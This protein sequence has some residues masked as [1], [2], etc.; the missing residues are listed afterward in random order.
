MLLLNY[1][2]NT[3]IITYVD[4]DNTYIAKIHYIIT[5]FYELVNYGNIGKKKGMLVMRKK[6]I[7]KYDGLPQFHFEIILDGNVDVEQFAKD[8]QVNV[9]SVEYLT[10]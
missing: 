6:V 7:Y 2:D 4:I 1:I 5:Y 9:L 8:N 3:Y 10:D